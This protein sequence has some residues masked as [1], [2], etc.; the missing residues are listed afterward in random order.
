MLQH[1]CGHFLPTGTITCI[2]WKSDHIVRGDADG[3]L[4]VWD[5]R[6][7]TSRN[8]ATHRG[9]IRKIRFAPGKGNFK[10]L[11][12]NV[13]AVSIWDVKECE[14]I[15][16]LRSPKDLLTRV[17]DIEWAASDRAVLATTD[18][19]LRIM[20]LSMASSTSGMLEYNVEET[21]WCHPLLPNKARANFHALLCHQPWRDKYSLAFSSADGFSPLEL[22][23]VEEQ[24]KHFP[25]GLR[26]ALENPSLSTA[27][28]CLMAARMSGNTWEADFWRVATS[29][30][31]GSGSGDDVLDTRFDVVCDSA[32]YAEYHRERVRLHET[33]CKGNRAQRKKVVDLLLCLGSTDEAV[34]LLLDSEPDGPQYYED[35]LRACLVAST[36]VSPPETPHS[37][38]KLVATNLIAEGKL[39][40]GVQLLCLI[41]KIPDACKYLQSC[42]RWHESLWL[43]KC[44]LKGEDLAAVA[45][46]YCEHCS[47]K[48][49]K[50]R[51]ALV[52]LSLRDFVSTLDVLVSAKMVSLAAPFLQACQESGV[53]P[54]TSHA[55]VLA[56]E[57][58]LGYA[59]YLFDQGNGP[60][61]FFYCDR[62]DEKGEI[63]KREMESL[64]SS[65]SK[66]DDADGDGNDDKKNG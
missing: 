17:S 33:R 60:G 12:L 11:V 41:N 61:A 66:D 63:L 23:F 50:K 15:N 14:M 30:M 28:R 65:S 13:D 26:Q 27:R 51:A 8:I 47:S 54:D 59:R 55:L 48:D 25:A 40:E 16:E 35:S 53:L 3:N 2:A 38:T 5:V 45:Q 56:E 34:R 32:S 43:A 57:I 20:G 37:T 39:W 49:Q 18:G 42:G 29:V 10:L 1:V 58:S 46:K 31:G 7:R 4:N 21:I 24:V 64:I 19:C 22:E 6:T 36:A 52:H 44:R 62:A 9:A